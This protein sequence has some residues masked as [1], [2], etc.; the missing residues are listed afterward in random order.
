MIARIVGSLVAVALIAGG[1]VMTMGDGPPTYTITADV[2]QAPSLFTRGRVMVRGVEVGTITDV[3]P[4]REG[5]RLTLEVRKDVK[6]PARASLAVVPITIIADRYVQIEPPYVSGALLQDGDHIPIERTT[7][8]AELDDVLKEL[9]G[10]LAALEPKRGEA[11]PLAS[12]ITNLDEAVDGRADEIGG[13][14]E[15]GAAVLGN[16]AAR[17]AELTGLIDNLDQVFVALANRSS[18]IGI[19]NERLQLVVEALAQDRSALEGTLENIA[20]LSREGA[21]LIEESGDDLGQSFGRLGRVLRAVL[22]HEDSLADGIKWANVINQA[23]GAT[24]ASG[25]GLYAFSGRQAA[26]GSTGAQYNYRID[27]RDTMACERIGLLAERFQEIN[28][29]WGFLEVKDAVLSYFPDTYIDDLE[30]LIDIL[31][32]L[33]ADLSPETELEAR[34]AAIVDAAA[35]A[36]GPKRLAKL[37]GRALP[38]VGR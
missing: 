13:T 37:A 21:S 5:V 31:I 17:E 27:T 9:K 1:V 26:P 30:F 15:G 6:I 20:F 18:E 4:Q 11:G 36:L 3:E 23:L 38:G 29:S 16:L 32:P 22:R 10:L 14:L 2:E 7:I 25:R 24:D 33:C 34:A 8:P 28:P 19:I 35:S 12:L